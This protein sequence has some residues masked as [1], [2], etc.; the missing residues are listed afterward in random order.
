MK[1]LL[2]KTTRAETSESKLKRYENVLRR[3]KEREQEE[4]QKMINKVMKKVMK[5]P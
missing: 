3:Q 1:D 5:T 4:E 2:N